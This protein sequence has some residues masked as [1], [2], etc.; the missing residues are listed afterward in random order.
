MTNSAENGISMWGEFIARMFITVLNINLFVYSDL[1][2]RSYWSCQN[3]WQQVGPEPSCD[4]REIWQICCL[5]SKRE[6]LSQGFLKSFNSPWNNWQEC[7]ERKQ[8]LGKVSAAGTKGAHGYCKEESQENAKRE[9]EG[10]KMFLEVSVHVQQL[11]LPWPTHQQSQEV[12]RI[13][14]CCSRVMKYSWKQRC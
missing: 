1:L 9:K 8:I 5:C 4:V 14:C 11:L 13:W 12:Y 2:S 6:A 7:A 10:E 3:G